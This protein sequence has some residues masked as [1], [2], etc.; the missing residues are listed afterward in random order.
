MDPGQQ[1]VGR[2]VERLA[3]GHDVGAELGEEA[4]EALPGGDR[5]HPGAP[6]AE[7][8]AA[9]GDLLAHV[10][11][12]EVRHLARPLEERDRR[13]GLVGVDV[14]LEGRFVADDEDRVAEPL[15][16]GQ[17]VARGQARRRRR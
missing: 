10:G 9:L 2:G 6:G 3:A 12:V 1:L 7:P 16:P 5:E 11:D 13:L 4:L 8:G 14:D 15:E 17:E